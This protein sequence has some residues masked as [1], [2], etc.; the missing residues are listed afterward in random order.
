[1]PRVPASVGFIGISVQTTMDGKL[2]ELGVHLKTLDKKMASAVRRRI[3]EG[4]RDGGSEILSAVRREASWSSR[5]PGATTLQVNYS[6]KRSGVTV[7]VNRTKAPHGRPIEMGNRG[8]QGLRH[9][10]FADQRKGRNEWTWVN[11]PVRPFFFRG[12]AAATPIVRARMLKVLDDVAAD[13][14]F[15]GNN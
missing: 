5:I 3:R 10:V 11:Q 13:L 1:M 9:P 12:V 6:E 4:I 7:V 14:G 8:S 15:T 2:A